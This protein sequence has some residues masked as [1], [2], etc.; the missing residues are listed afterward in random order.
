[1]QAPDPIASPDPMPVAIPAIP[2]CGFY[3]WIAVTTMLMTR[4]PPLPH[5]RDKAVSHLTPIVRVFRHP[6][7]EDSLLVEQ[8]PGERRGEGHD[9]EQSPSRAQCRR[10]AEQHDQRAEIQSGGPPAGRDRSRRAAAPRP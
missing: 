8:P 5:E 2:G 1:M 9:R 4:G 3:A 7:R 6:R 10:H